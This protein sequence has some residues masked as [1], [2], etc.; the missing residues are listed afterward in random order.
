[1]L[2]SLVCRSAKPERGVASRIFRSWQKQL[3]SHVYEMAGLDVFR[4]ALVGAVSA[5]GVTEADF[6]ARIALSLREA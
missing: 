6:R 5:A 3:E 1:M 2:L 4:C